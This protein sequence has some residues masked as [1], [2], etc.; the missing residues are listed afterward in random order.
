VNNIPP[1]VCTYSCVY[2]QVGR[3]TRAQVERSSFYEPE[4][5]VSEIRSKIEK[6]RDAGEP[7]DYVTFVP[8][9]EPALDVNL[10]REIELLRPLDV[11][12]A[13][14]SNASLISRADVREDLAKADWVSLKVDAADDAHWRKVN[15]PHRALALGDIFEGMIKFAKSYE[16]KLITETMLVRDLNDDEDQLKG[17]AGFLSVLEPNTAYLSVPTRPPTEQ[18]VALPDS[19]TINRAYQIVSDKVSNVELLIGYE[20]NA[21]A[22]TGNVEEDLL[23]IM[24]VHPMTEEAVREFLDK[25]NADETVLRRL[26]EQGRLLRTSYRG[27]DFYLG[28]PRSTKGS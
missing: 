4:D 2:C 27:E 19:E 1:K 24:A 17:I 14:I 5:L 15:R 8:D 28:M 22:F 13:V 20:G 11:R 21:F 3:T 9:G 16:G 18:W 10:G 7:V 25:A 6:A 12:I 26:V 23:S